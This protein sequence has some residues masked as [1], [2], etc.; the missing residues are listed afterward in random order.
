MSSRHLILG[1]ESSCDDTAA[2]VVDIEGNV[3]SSVIATQT[4]IHAPHGG[5]YP[6]F[7]SRA[8]VLSVIPTIKSALEQANAEGP[9]LRAIGVTRGRRRH[10]RGVGRPRLRRPAA[11]DQARQDQKRRAEEATPA[12]SAR[13]RVTRGGSDFHEVV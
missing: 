9:D 11:P 12:S 3:L 6:E 10:I 2:S 1:I 7:A 13:E 4:H 5:I 8:H